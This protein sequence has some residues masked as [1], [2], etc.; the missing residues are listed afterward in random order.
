MDI[1]RHLRKAM[2]R[3]R[4]MNHV[5]EERDIDDIHVPYHMCEIVGQMARR[6]TWQ[7]ILMKGD[8][9]HES[10][11]MRIAQIEEGKRVLSPEWLLV[12]VEWS[13]DHHLDVAHG[14]MALLHF[15]SMFGGWWD[16]IELRIILDDAFEQSMKIEMVQAR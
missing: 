16:P 14:I 8:P 13:R 11:R 15:R 10:D 7:T 5:V 12:A 2:E 6:I 1:N 3:D 4:C 9:T